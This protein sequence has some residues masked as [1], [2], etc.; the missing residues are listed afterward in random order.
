MTNEVVKVEDPFEI[1][2][3]ISKCPP[4]L[5]RAIAF[6]LRK[7]GIPTDVIAQK[8]GLTEGSVHNAVRQFIKEHQPERDVNAVIDMELLRLDELQA[9]CWQTAKQGDLKAIETI[10]KIMSQRAKLLG[11]GP[12]PSSGGVSTTTNNVLI[13]GG[14]EDEYINALKDAQRAARTLSG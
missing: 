7:V 8:L 6:N 1:P 10:L 13:I 14:T 3:D 12:E 11:I 4:N 5:K 9:V 2:A